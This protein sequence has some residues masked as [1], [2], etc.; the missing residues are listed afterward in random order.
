MLAFLCLYLHRT[1]KEETTAVAKESPF[2][3][4]DQTLDSQ[5]AN[6]LGDR[7]ENRKKPSK[8]DHQA[9]RK[10][11]QRGGVNFKNRASETMFPPPGIASASNSKRKGA[12]G[13]GEKAVKRTKKT[14]KSSSGNS[15]AKAGPSVEAA[16]MN[17]TDSS[18]V[19]DDFLRMFQ[20]S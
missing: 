4:S 20:V 8:T 6:L 10:S 18:S 9:K 16:T 11:K 12:T 13:T 15:D 1:G 17:L 19:H 3:T 7:A 14:G 5:V 2:V